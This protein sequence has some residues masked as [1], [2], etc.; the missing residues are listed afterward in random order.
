MQNPGIMVGMGG[1]VTELL[2]T[3]REMEARGYESLWVPE[4]HNAD[5][6]VRLAAVAARTS[7]MTLV[8]GI[9]NAFNRAPAMIAAAA[10]DIDEISGGRFIL[11][12]GTGTRKMQEAWYG[13]TYDPPAPKSEELIEL[14]R[15]FWKSHRGG[16]FQHA[17]KYFNVDID[18]YG[19]VGLL[20]E[21][22]PVYLA[23]V[24][25][26][27]VRAAGQVADGLVGHPL[28][29]KQWLREAVAPAVAD[30][31]A[32]GGR[33]REDFT[34]ASF[35]ITAVSEDREEARR[36][37]SLQVAF[38]ATVRTYAPIL[39][40][41]GWGDAA[42]GIR[43]AFFGRDWAALAKSLPDGMLDEIAIYGTAAECRDQLESFE[44]LMDLPVLYPP[45]FALSGAESRRARE[46]VVRAFARGG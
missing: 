34:L 45:S 5:G 15:S 40:L 27:M 37:A 14:L 7:R 22:I 17:G 13:L 35:I 31:L 8:S 18:T 1:P 33:S 41:S 30:G 3:A 42:E 19:R 28:Y 10:A 11:G 21:E 12:L 23:G 20:R 26:R 25:R 4:F 38:Y 16:K 32:R 6:L 44:G 2:E 9:A 36:W 39:E 46:G 43:T 24:N 29:S